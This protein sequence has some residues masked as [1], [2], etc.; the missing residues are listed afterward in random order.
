AIVALE[1]Y[2]KVDRKPIEHTS[3][4]NSHYHSRRLYWRYR[5]RLLLVQQ[6]RIVSSPRKCDAIVLMIQDQVRHADE[7][8]FF[9]VWIK[10]PVYFSQH[11]R[12]RRVPCR[13]C[14]QHAAANRHDQR[15]RDAFAGNVCD[16]NAKSLLIDMDVIEIITA[17]LAGWHINAA[18]L[19]P[20]DGRRFRWEQDALN[21]S[22]DFEVVIQPFLFVRHGVNDRVIERKGRLLGDGFKN[23]KISLRKRRTHWTVGHCENTEV[24]VAISERCGHDRHAAKRASP[25]FGQFRG[26]REFV[27]T[28]SLTCLPDA[29]NQSFVRTNRMEP[30][31]SLKG[32]RIG[33]RLL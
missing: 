13:L 1:R 25:Q 17:Y 22:R 11:I 26:F 12:R 7:H 21:V 18:N 3:A 29:S 27:E 28:N 31:E 24:L 16:C 15:C 30:Q 5:L 19:E 10:L 6:R 14:T 8:V 2:R 23:D 33:S 4:V 20:I 32:D 9:N